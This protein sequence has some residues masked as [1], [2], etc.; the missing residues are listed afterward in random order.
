MASI[1]LMRLEDYEPVYALW[2]RI[3]GMGLRSLDDSREGISRYLQRNPSTCFVAVE[4]DAVI[5]V[6]LAGHDGRRGFL[7]HLAV[8]ENHRGQG[9][10]SALLAKAVTALE[11]EG[12]HKASLVVKANNELGNTFWQAKG[13]TDRPDL[14]YRNQ[15][16]NDENQ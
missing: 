1:R 13:W 11:A 6:I 12:I 10:G 7:Y 16:F 8:A 9:I 5:G 14:V 15:S 4:A 2:S 3:D